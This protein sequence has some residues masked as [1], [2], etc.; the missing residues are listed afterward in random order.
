MGARTWAAVDLHIKKEFVAQK[1]NSEKEGSYIS[2]GGALPCLALSSAC[3][4][5]RPAGGGCCIRPS[6]GRVGLSE[7]K[8]VPLDRGVSSGR[9]Q[10]PDEPDHR[11]HGSASATITKNSTCRLDATPWR[12]CGSKITYKNLLP[13][14]HAFRV[15]VSGR[16][17]GR[18]RSATKKARWTINNTPPSAPV[19]SGGYHCLDG[20]PGDDPGA[21]STDPGGGIARYDLAGRVGV[22]RRRGR[23]RFGVTA[24]RADVEFQMRAVDTA[25]NVSVWAPAVTGAAN[26]A[27]IETDQPPTAP[28][29]AGALAG[30][31]APPFPDR[32]R[33]RLDR[34]RLGHRATGTAPR[35]TP[36]RRSLAVQLGALL[37]VSAEGRTD[38]QFRAVDAV[39]NH[40]AW[41]QAAVRLDDSAPT[42]PRSRAARRVATSPSVLTAG[43]ARPTPAGAG[44]GRLRVPDLHRRWLDL[45]GPGGRELARRERRGRDAR[46]VRRRRRRRPRDLLL[47]AAIVRLDHGT[48]R[49]GAHGGSLRGR[50]WPS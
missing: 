34:R 44:R 10:Q 41:A 30:S 27:M 46:P 39:G 23:Q 40:S 14:A 6:A 9:I 1:P 3:P 12:T 20:R 17:G 50:T 26:T 22:E 11:Q 7:R 37:A 24:C 42:T 28:P 16:V 49:P 15:K 35:S 29:L 18:M 36:A 8:P 5:G 31:A 4:S 13:G 2:P 48:V 21:G 45:V 32:D 19:V 33:G 47:D 25:G 43:P 38:L